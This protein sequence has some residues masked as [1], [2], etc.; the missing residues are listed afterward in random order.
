MF[1]KGKFR[2]LKRHFFKRAG[3]FAHLG[4]VDVWFWE[5]AYDLG[6]FGAQGVTF[7]LHGVCWVC[8]A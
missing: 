3:G 1:I 7:G 4:Q 2:G 5:V 8:K 6:L